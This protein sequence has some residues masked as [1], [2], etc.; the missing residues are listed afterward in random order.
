[1]NIS[2]GNFLLVMSGV[3]AGP[4]LAKQTSKPNFVFIL[5]DDQGWNGLSVR[6]HPDVPGSKSEYCQTPELEKLASQGMRFSAA[7]SPAP[8]CSPTRISL[9]TGKSPAQLHWTKASPVMTAS[10]NYRMIS[11]KIHKSIP[12]EEVTIAEML[13]TAGYAC[14]H[15][16]KW[17]LDNGGP[18]EHGYDRSDGDTGNGDA[19]PF[20]DPNPVD[21]FGITRRTNQFM[22]ENTRAGKPFYVQLSHHALHYPENALKKTLEKYGKLMN[23]VMGKNVGRAAITENLDTGVG[24]VMKKIDDL[25]IWHNTYLIY[26]SDNGGGGG[27]KGDKRDKKGKKGDRG[28]RGESG[29]DRKKPLTGGKGS[30]WEGGI[31]VPLIIRGPGIKPNTFCHVPVVGYDL[32]PTFCSLAGVSRPMP[33]GV[34]GGS[35]AELLEKGRGIVRRARKELF[36][37]F[38]HYQSKDGPHSVI[39][40]GDYKLLKFYETGQVRLHDLSKDIGEENDLAKKMPEKTEDLKKRLESYLKEINAQMPKMNPDYDPSKPSR[41]P[42]GGKK[43]KKKGGRGRG[44]DKR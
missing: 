42:K 21:I 25:G 39:I 22:E 10:D 13:K 36:F 26:M 20:I 41:D 33:E 11:P 31:R 28:D 34:E 32:F 9:Q 8:V 29:K 15:F 12:E 30:L 43:K 16:G 23:E 2:R 24:M 7:Y 17:H 18:E 6:M 44:R 35:I 37:H 19:A 27:G 5:S 3:L 14:A 4:V 40:S 1:M 38:P